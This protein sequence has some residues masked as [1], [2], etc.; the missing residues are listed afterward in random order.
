MKYL[1]AYFDYRFGN[2][3]FTDDFITCSDDFVVLSTIWNNDL[4]YTVGLSILLQPVFPCLFHSTVQLLSLL[5][6]NM[7]V[8]VLLLEQK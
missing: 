6:K 4:L 2:G 3:F 7:C 8:W 1:L 5:Y